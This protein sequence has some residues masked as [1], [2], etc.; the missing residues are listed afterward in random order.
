MS[1]GVQQ[2]V[3]HV[4]VVVVGAGLSGVGAACRIQEANPG[5]DYVVR[6]AR[7][8]LGGTWDQFP[9]PGVR[10]DSDMYTMSY[11]FAPWHQEKAIAAGEDILDYIRS[12]A[13]AFGVSERIRLR[14]KVVSAD[15]S[16]ADAVWRLRVDTPDGEVE[17]TAGFIHACSGYY[18][19]AEPYAA[20]IPALAEFA[21]QVVHPQF[22]P[23]DLDVA[24]RRVVVIGSGATAMT[25]VP[26][27]ADLGAEVTMLQRTPTYVLA[28]PSRDPLAAALA[29]IPDERLSP[30]R[31]HAV[32]RAKNVAAQWASYQTARRLPRAARAVLRANVRQGAGAEHVDSFTAPYA[33]WDQRLCIVPDGDLFKAVKHGRARVVTDTIASVEPG[34]VRTGSGELFETD[35]IVTATGLAVELLGGAS[36]RID[37][38]PV[39]VSQRLVYRGCMLEGV[40]NA[41]LCVGYINASWSLRGDL[42]HRFVARMIQHLRDGRY[43]S[44]TPVPPSGLGRR[45]LLEMDSGYLRRAADIMPRRSDAAPWTMRQ[46]YLAEAR[47]MRR[48]DVTTDVVFA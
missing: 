15:W 47:E 17:T 43:R 42:S 40:P 2:Q 11:P 3:E 7:D 25:L 35:V 1:V 13:D 29:K 46:N 28:Q 19:Y 32:M 9:Y 30:Q 26:A 21:G 20:D 18:S 45:P 37:G 34:G 16:S 36:L 44:A 27:L 33:P 48:P 22:W 6:E 14:H 4:D 31:K 38:E 5:V 12:T 23:Q 8:A 24:G 39:D 10:T 41:A